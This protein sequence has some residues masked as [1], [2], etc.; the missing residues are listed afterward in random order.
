M[1]RATTTGAWHLTTQY[2]Y[3]LDTGL[4]RAL[5][6]YVQNKTV[7]DIGAGKG[8]YVMF[9]NAYGVDVHGLEGADNID[10]VRSTPLVQHADL[11]QKLHP[12]VQYDWTLFLVANIFQEISSRLSSITSTAP[13][14]T[15]S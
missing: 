12:C 1:A 7:V 5:I 4:A 9:L 10:A 3:K 2:V 13:H 11:T 15:K 6:P 8:R 14:A